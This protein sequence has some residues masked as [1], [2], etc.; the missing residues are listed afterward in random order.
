MKNH[1]F[2][3]RHN[4]T[5]DIK[6]HSMDHRAGLRLSPLVAALSGALVIL[7]STQAVAQQLNPPTQHR[8]DLNNPQLVQGNSNLAA[9][10][11]VGNLSYATSTAQVHKLI[12]RSDKEK[13]AADGR[14]VVRIS[15]Q[16]VGSDDQT[17]NAEIPVL[18][19][20]TLGRITLPG[21]GSTALEAAMDRD[22][23]ALGT[24]VIVKGG[25]L[26][27]ELIAPADPGQALIRVSVGGR[28]QTIAVNFEPDLREMIAVGLVEGAIVLRK[29]NGGLQTVRPGDGFEQEI[30]RFQYD[31]NDGKG[32][33]GVRAGF[34]L[35]G[36]ISG[37]TL[38]T[39]AYDSDKDVRDRMF[40]DIRAD[41]FYP[42]YGD[43][44]L[45]GYDAQTSGRFFVRVDNGKN[46]ALY[47]DFNTADTTN[48]D[49]V[50]LGRYNRSLTG[51]KGHWENEHASATAFVSRDSLRQ[52]VDELPGKGISG[53]YAAS[54]ANG[55]QNTEKVES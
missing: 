12:L 40:R 39:A 5:F 46:Y 42:V 24:Q 27:F 14:S 4:N 35:K 31:F 9:P 41:D 21:Q 54:F 29:Q 34:F 36:K 18:L 26:N 47:G 13:S 44:S 25:E 30:R 8:D 3:H 50:Q 7:C 17:V 33:W 49:A 48:V 53:P 45:K 22:K 28:Q 38:L 51:A 15:L 6:E 2:I 19:E 23:T 20:T 52:V 16:L 43:A 1:P 32:A 55:V 37:E 10:G 11:L